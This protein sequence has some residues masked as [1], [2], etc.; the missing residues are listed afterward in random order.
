MLICSALSRSSPVPFFSG[1]S[2]LRRVSADDG[3]PYE[4][5]AQPHIATG[6]AVRRVLLHELAD[7]LVP[8]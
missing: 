6:P 3:D 5:E 2:A 7:V 8:R 1:F 4:P